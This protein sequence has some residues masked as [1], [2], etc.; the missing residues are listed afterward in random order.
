MSNVYYTKSQTPIRFTNQFVKQLGFTIQPIAS[1]GYYL[2][3]INDYHSANSQHTQCINWYWHWA[4]LHARAGNSAHLTQ[5]ALELLNWPLCGHFRL[6]DGMNWNWID[7]SPLA[8]GIDSPLDFHWWKTCTESTIISCSIVSIGIKQQWWLTL[9]PF[10]TPLNNFRSNS[11]V[12]FT[13][14]CNSDSTPYSIN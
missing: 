12:K 13:V 9:R 11:K 1:C 10:R 5:A 3:P 7:S 4:L 6:I 8:T 14:A 2:Q